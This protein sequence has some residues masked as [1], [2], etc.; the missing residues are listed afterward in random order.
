MS[1][2]RYKAESGILYVRASLRPFENAIRTAGG[3]EAFLSE[4]FQFQEIFAPYF[5]RARPFWEKPLSQSS[6][7]NSGALGK[8]L[9][10]NPEAIMSEHPSHSFVGVGANVKY[11]LTRHDYLTHPSQLRF[12]GYEVDSSR[13]VMKLKK[14][15]QVKEINLW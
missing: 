9:A 15:I 4:H 10:K 12:G 6:P 1:I 14:R 5:K 13:K 2:P 3:V 8:Q 7:T 11:A